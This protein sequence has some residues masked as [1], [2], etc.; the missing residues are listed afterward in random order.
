MAL[1]D[2][3]MVLQSLC[4]QAFSLIVKEVQKKHMDKF[5]V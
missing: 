1:A 5:E 2:E 3:D 4:V